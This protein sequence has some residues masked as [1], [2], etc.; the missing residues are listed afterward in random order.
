MEFSLQ[1]EKEAPDAGDPER[2]TAVS[3]ARVETL[4]QNIILG[5]VIGNVAS[6][7]SGVVQHSTAVVKRD[8]DS[9]TNILQGLG[10][11]DEDIRAL[12]VTL[13]EEEA[14]SGIGPKTAGWL[15]KVS[16]KLA[17]GS[18]KVGEGVTVGTIVKA[19]TSF[20]RL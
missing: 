2:E 12:T 10:V 4:Y 9:L 3:P 8:V 18:L 6:G 15:S 16:E 5:D 13:K 20:L 1:L 11:P 19:I 17:S 7:G 14:L